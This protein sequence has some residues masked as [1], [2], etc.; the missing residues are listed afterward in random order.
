VVLLFA[1]FGLFLSNFVSID[2]QG[3][4]APGVFLSRESMARYIAHPITTGG[5]A[6]LYLE[7]LA[8][9]VLFVFAARLW[10]RLR[11]AEGDPAWL[12]AIALG[13]QL[14]WLCLTLISLAAE[15]AIY[16][17]AGQ[18]ADVGIALTLNDLQRTTYFM[19]W[20]L[21]ALFLSATAAVALR[22]HALPRWLGWSAAGIAVLL[23]VALLVPTSDLAQNTTFLVVFWIAAASIVLLRQGE[24]S[25]PAVSVASVAS[26]ASA[27]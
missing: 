11:R 26:S 20:A 5:W 2:S 17:R 22:T 8:A 6:G 1:G 27:G 10:V 14:G 3:Q 23:A 13:A 25:R 19:S 15:A 9:F 4:Q 12:A 16:V 7:T 21:T 24:E 18:G